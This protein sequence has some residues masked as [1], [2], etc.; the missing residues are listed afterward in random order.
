MLFFVEYLFLLIILEELVYEGRKSA[1]LFRFSFW[2]VCSV[3]V[4]QCFI[5]YTVF[6]RLKCC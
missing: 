4:W 1:M 6:L 3:T 5:V 2:N